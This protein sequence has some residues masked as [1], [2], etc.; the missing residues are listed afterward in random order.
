M[1][2]IAQLFMPYLLCQD[3]AHYLIASSHSPTG[4]PY[5]CV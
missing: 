5:F 1:L 2:A 4:M 3:L